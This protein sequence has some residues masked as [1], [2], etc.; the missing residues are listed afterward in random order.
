MSLVILILIYNLE[1]IGVVPDIEYMSTNSRFVRCDL[2]T[3]IDEIDIPNI[4]L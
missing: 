4:A 2:I 1:P 3:L